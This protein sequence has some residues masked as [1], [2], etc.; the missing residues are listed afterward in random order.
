M[1]FKTS[2]QAETLKQFRLSVN[3]S[4]FGLYMYFTNERIHDINLWR[5]KVASCLEHQRT[6]FQKKKVYGDVNSTYICLQYFST[7]EN[8]PVCQKLDKALDRK[9]YTANSHIIDIFLLNT[10]QNPWLKH[11]RS[12]SQ[13]W[14][15]LLSHKYCY[16]YIQTFFILFLCWAE[17]H[18]SGDVYC[19]RLCS[20]LS[21]FL[22]NWM[23]FYYLFQQLCIDIVPPGTHMCPHR[24]KHSFRHLFR[25]LFLCSSSKSFNLKILELFR[26]VLETWKRIFSVFSLGAQTIQLIL[27]TQPVLFCPQKHYGHGPTLFN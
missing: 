22:Q 26:K 19:V 11:C 17:G 5:G 12:S 18:A 13:I 8:L 25:V 1:C 9:F 6:L 16:Q 10:H 27:S 21:S 20:S 23:A 2:P 15:A 7:G 14:P 3:S 24:E 4:L